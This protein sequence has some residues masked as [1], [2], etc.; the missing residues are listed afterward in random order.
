MVRIFRSKLTPPAYQECLARPRLVA[1]ESATGLLVA[2]APG[3]AGTTVF[4]VQWMEAR[5]GPAV[6]YELDEQDRD[7][8]VFAAHM[9]AGLRDVWA[10]WDPAPAAAGD[11]AQLA[12]ELVSEAGVR[13]PLTLVI[14][15]LEQAFGQPYLADFLAVV[16]RYVPPG[17]TVGLATRAPLPVNLESAR[18]G[19]RL[20]RAADLAL[21]PEEAESLLGPGSWADWP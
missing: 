4:L 12:V 14:D 1:G 10:G 20:V 15:R 19:W 21:T 2:Q 13:P 9:T 6:Y 16:L 7:G 17:L 5:D 18:H 3:G 11:P 8:A